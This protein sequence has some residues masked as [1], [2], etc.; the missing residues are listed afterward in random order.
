MNRGNKK[1]SLDANKLTQINELKQ[2]LASNR[3]QIRQ[4]EDESNKTAELI[5]VL[6]L[7][8]PDILNEQS[9]L[10]DSNSNCLISQTN[11]HCFLTEILQTDYHQRY[12]TTIS[13]IPIELYFDDNDITI[14]FTSNT[15]FIDFVKSMKLKL[16]LNP[17]KDTIKSLETSLKEDNC[18]L[19]KLKNELNEQIKLYPEE[20]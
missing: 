3:T 2:V 4:L 1:I 16:N 13:N 15:H 18:R 20:I 19:E 7:S 8:N 17:L 9:W 14:Y 5:L 11:K 12:S 6:V 10:I